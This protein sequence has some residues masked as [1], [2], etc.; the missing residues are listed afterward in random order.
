MHAQRQRHNAPLP[1]CFDCHLQF[2]PASTI[3]AVLALALFLRAFLGFSISRDSILLRYRNANAHRSSHATA[4]KS[5]LRLARK[6]AAYIL[7]TAPGH[8][9]R[10]AR[11]CFRFDIA[12][13]AISARRQRFLRGQ[14]RRIGG[15][16]GAQLVGQLLRLTCRTAWPRWQREAGGV[17][18]CRIISRESDIISCQRYFRR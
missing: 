14:T 9:Y 4:K 1:R 16:H 10:R 6:Y 17:F 12:F 2:L 3:S 11:R 8:T 18:R 13:D 15:I 7:I 5:A